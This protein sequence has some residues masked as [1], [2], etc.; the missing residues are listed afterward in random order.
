VDRSP[1]R[2]I[3]RTASQLEGRSQERGRKIGAY[4]IAAAKV[5]WCGVLHSCDASPA[6][7]RLHGSPIDLGELFILKKN[8]REATCKLRSHQFG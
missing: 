2:S 4:S 6:T 5:I 3:H 7:S 8:G 1:R